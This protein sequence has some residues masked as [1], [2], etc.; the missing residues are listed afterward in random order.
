[1]LHIPRKPITYFT[2][3]KNFVEFS[4]YLEWVEKIGSAQDEAASIKMFQEK[5]VGG[6][7]F[8]LVI[9]VDGVPS[10]MIDLHELS[11]TNAIC[12]MYGVPLLLMVELH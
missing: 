4:K 12:F 5:M 6:K 7:A 9:L 11:K 8:N 2:L 1:M 10:G 3:Q